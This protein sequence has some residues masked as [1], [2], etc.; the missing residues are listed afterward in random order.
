MCGC[1]CAKTAET[2]SAATKAPVGDHVVR[3]DDMTCGH[4]V[5]TITKAIQAK[6][7]AAAVTAD[8]AGK[9]VTVLG[10]QPGA[11]VGGAIR[12]AGFTPLG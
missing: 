6:W 9:T 3:V 1:G 7:P 5:A 8:L 2:P 11:D 4:C 12:E 10:V